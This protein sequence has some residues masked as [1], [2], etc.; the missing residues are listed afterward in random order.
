MNEPDTK[1]ASLSINGIERPVRPLMAQLAAFSP[2]EGVLEA[3]KTFGALP[4]EERVALVLSYEPEIFQVESTTRCNL[5]CPLCSTHHL[6]RGYR[7]S[8]LKMIREIQAQ[9]PCLRYMCLHLMG[10]PLLS[11]SLSE[12]IYFLK[13]KQVF[14]YFAT[15]GM[16]L[17][18]KV[19]EILSSGLD[20]ISV[21][22]D[23]ITQ[24]DLGQYRIHA[25]LE[26]ILRGIRALRAGREARGLTRPLIQVQTIMFPYNQPKEAQIIAFLKEL[27]VDRIK[28]KRPS[29]ETF[30]GKNDAT[31]TFADQ[32]GRV[33]S[34]YSRSHSSYLRYRDRP[35]C[36]LLLQ[37]FILADGSVVPCCIDYDGTFSFGNVT[38]QSWQEIRNAT[39]RRE[40]L[41]RYFHG[42]M[43]ICKGC[44]LGYAYSTTVFDQHDDYLRIADTSRE[45][46]A[47]A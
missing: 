45:K 41:E 25:D 24:T 16:L 6:R 21:S 46:T 23:G 22:L 36:R 37:G 47:I 27:G 33:K 9:N 11:P 19:D 34:N 3:Q 35:L 30:G 31:N 28:L 44:S 15:N 5:R 39:R 12:I 18:K 4:L 43:Q 40:I 7:D 13:S 26:T 2:D 8:D 32:Y 17:E 10:E 14:T 1:L 20:K 38:K 42:E 29:F